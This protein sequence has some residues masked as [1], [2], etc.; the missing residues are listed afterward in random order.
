MACNDLQAYGSWRPVTQ[1]R[2]R[3]DAI[4]VVTPCADHDLRLPQAVEDLPLETLVLE[5]AIKAFAVSVLPGA[6]RLDVQAL[7]AELCQPPTES[8]GDHLRA[9]VAANMLGHAFFEHGVCERLDYSEA[10]D[11]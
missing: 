7:G 1:G 3:P 11:P 9:V 8:L 10:V 4:V 2:V 5:L 6:A